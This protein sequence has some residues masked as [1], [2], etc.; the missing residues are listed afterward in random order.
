MKLEYN[1]IMCWYN[2]TSLK[3]IE[4]TE[5]FADANLY[6]LA[7]TFAQNCKKLSTS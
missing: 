1:R 7:K 5:L 2:Y 4:T 3:Q 6:N